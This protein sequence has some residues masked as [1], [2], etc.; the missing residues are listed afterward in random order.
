MDSIL[1]FIFGKSEWEDIYHDL[2][3]LEEE[4]KEA[5]KLKPAKRAKRRKEIKS[6]TDRIRIRME[7]LNK[8]ESETEEDRFFKKNN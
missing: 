8:K 2:E 6:K 7:H 5:D 3:A 1:D 4:S